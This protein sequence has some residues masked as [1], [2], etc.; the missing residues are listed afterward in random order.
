MIIITIIIIAEVEKRKKTKVF[1]IYKRVNR[2]K[3][4]V[5]GIQLRQQQTSILF[6]SMSVIS[7][8]DEK[9]V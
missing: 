5:K 3:I 7:D 9:R 2:G 8:K 1:I 6:S 4:T